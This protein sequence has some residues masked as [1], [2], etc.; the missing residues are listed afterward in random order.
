VAG[1]L[2]AS[3]IV[4]A[5]ICRPAAPA[6]K[7]RSVY[8]GGHRMTTLNR[9]AALAVL[10]AALAAATASAVGAA[11]AASHK[12]KPIPSFKLRIGTV[13][14]F[15][16]DLSAVGPSIDASA[17]LATDVINAAL[18][19]DKLDKKISVKIV[20]SQDDQT[21][22]QPAIEAATKEVKVDKVNVIIG[23]MS[24]QSTI[25]MAQAVTIP[26]NVVVITPTSSAPQITTLQDNNTVWRILPSDLFQGKAM[27]AAVADAFGKTATI[28]VG[29]RNDAFGTAL[30]QVF[31]ATWKANGGKI[32]TEVSWD[33]NQASFDSEA[34]KLTSGNPAGWVI[35]DFPETF[36][37]VGPALI[38]TGK[39]T[40]AKT[41]MNDVMSIPASLTQVG[42][43]ATTGLRGVAPTSQSASVKQTGA[44]AKLFKAKKPGKPVTGYEGTSFDSVMLAFLAALQGRS[45][46]PNAIKAN[47]R[48]ISGPTGTPV[49]YLNL[50][51]GIKLVLAGKRIAYQGVWGPIDYDQN[52]DVGSS[53]FKVWSYDGTTVNTVKI[54]Q[55]G[56]K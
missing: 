25:A 17:R 48:G 19:K 56:G 3:P 14:P 54:F 47:L 1:K 46:S 44:F 22:T 38:R 34:Q 5:N 16:G 51:Q 45:S 27:A 6:A 9:W 7:G 21:S 43:Q 20:D 13:L 36:A 42:A 52:G 49:S 11:P 2:R 32:G 15:T 41:F 26:N 30:E 29:S 50:A 39:W 10:G 23:T 53:L 24:S 4:Y 33:P 12:A 18:K 28:N 37:K 35:I 31:A 8:E 40:P 55:Y